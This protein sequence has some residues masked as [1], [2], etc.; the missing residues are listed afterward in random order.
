MQIKTGLQ[1][2]E[3]NALC[4]ISFLCLKMLSH[5]Y[6]WPQKKTARYPLKSQSGGWFLPRFFVRE[7]SK[8]IT[9]FN[10]T[11]CDLFSIIIKVYVKQHIY[12]ITSMFVFFL[13]CKINLSYSKLI[14]FLALN[15]LARK[16]QNQNNLI[17][18]SSS[19][20]FSLQ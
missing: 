8:I 6:P 2:T 17:D 20:S 10:S 9:K 1:Q 11:K 16:N 12:R 18:F 3:K 7:R 15:P 5:D 14:D 19:D 4:L 13:K